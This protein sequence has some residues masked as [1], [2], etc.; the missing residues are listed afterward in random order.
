MLELSGRNPRDHA[1]LQCLRYSLRV[2]EVV[3]DNR[4]HGVRRMD[5]RSDGVWIRGKGGGEYF[6]HLPPALLA[7]LAGLAH[8]RPEQRLFPI[9]ERQAE[10]IV[11]NLAQAASVEDSDYVSPHRLRAFFATD[12]KDRGIDGFTIRDLM[13]H[14][15][16]Q[17]TNLYVGPPTAKR[18]AEIIASLG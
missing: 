14:K 4:L 15:N 16:I 11:K 3:G 13:R 17:T 9:T 18:Q 1:L 7:E 5:L 2:G 6:I 10:R 8:A 12:L